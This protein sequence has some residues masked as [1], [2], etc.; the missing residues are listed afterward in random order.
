M[1]G[2]LLKI[3]VVVLLAY[4][5]V[6]ANAGDDSFPARSSEGFQYPRPTGKHQVGTSYLF[7]ED[8]TRLDSFSDAQ[9]DYRWISVRVWYPAS[10]PSGATS[11]PYGYDEFNR[12]MVENGIFNPAYLDEVAL[13]PSASFRDVPFV[14]QEA[15]WPILIYSSSGVI[16]ANVFLCEELASQGYVVFAVGHPYW[17]EFYFDAEGELFYFDKSNKHYTA[18]WAEED[19]KTTKETKERITR[20]TDADTKLALYKEL[21]EIMPTEVSDLVLWQEDIDF[22]IDKLIELN[23]S[24]GFYRGRLDTERIGIMGYSKGGALAGQICA[25]SDRVRA[26]VNFDGFMFGGVVENDLAKPFMIFGQIV[27]WCQECPSINLPFF[28]RAGADA[29]LVE[30]ADANHATFTD[31]PL[32]KKYILPVGILSSL[33]GTKSTSIIRS[34]VLALFDT[35]V[36]GVPRAS[37]LDEVPSSFEAVKFMRRTPGSRRPAPR[38]ETIGNDP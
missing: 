19:A 23:K 3:A 27:S 18:M 29:Y 36:K 25:T 32:L 6:A 9:G 21:N 7:L 4:V 10:P 2:V 12:S 31:L 30:I 28:K 22:L 5:S 17:C 13:Q 38:P 26:G 15:P 35:Y 20:A 33:D 11:A 24:D 8:S 34:Y 16:T 14:S 37:I 1:R